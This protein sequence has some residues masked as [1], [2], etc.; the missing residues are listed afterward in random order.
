MKSQ[1]QLFQLPPDIHYLNGAYMTPLLTSVYEAGIEGLQWKLNP[2]TITPDD[3]FRLPESVREKFGALI[4]SPSTQI[5]IIPSASYGLKTAINN[6]PKNSGNHAVVIEHEFPSDYY[7]ISNWCRVNGQSLKVIAAPENKNNRGK[8]WNERIIDAI[9]EE[10][11]AVVLTP[12]HWADGTQF[13]LKQIGAKCKKTGSRFI[14]D[15][16]QS[17]GILNIDVADFHI[18]ALVCAAYKW[19]LG[20]YSIGVAYYNEK[21]DQGE[22]IED[23]W[24]NRINAEDFSNLTVFVDEYKPGAARYNMGEFT[25]PIHIKMLDR[26]LEMISSWGV[27]ALQEY[28]GNLVL[29]LIAY[30]RENDLWIEEDLYRANHLFG[31]KLPPDADKQQ[32]V[33]KL[34]AKKVFVSLRGDSIRVSPHVYNDENDITALINS[35]KEAKLNN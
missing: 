9:T 34:Q 7:A 17:V 23:S 14:V 18:D 5:A 19:L 16:T 35:L 28:C 20:P 12:V 11:T 21:Y 25:N 13:N 24:M 30:L 1:K 2:S 26:S 29:P 27:D 15:G 32:V 8:T 4:N 31:F 22:P 6:L 33:Q 3:F 10:T